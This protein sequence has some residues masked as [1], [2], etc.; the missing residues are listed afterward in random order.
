MAVGLTPSKSE[1]DTIA[2]VV[3]RDLHAALRKVEAFQYFLNGKSDA[4]LVTI[5]YTVDEV[6][7]LRS[8][9]G[10]AMELNRIYKGNQLLSV[11]KDF[12]TFLRQIFGMGD[13]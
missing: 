11:V 13:V 2:G 6:A 8:A 7:V 1:I 5:G 9:F 10:D 3:A 4:E 12:R